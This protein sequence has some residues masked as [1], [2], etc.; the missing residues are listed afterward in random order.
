MAENSRQSTSSC[1]AGLL[2]TSNLGGSTRPFL[3]QNPRSGHLQYYTQ[4]Q[5]VWACESQYELRSPA[6]PTAEHEA[7]LWLLVDCCWAMRERGR[8]RRRRSRGAAEAAVLRAGLGCWGWGLGP[9][10]WRWRLT[11]QFDLPVPVPGAWGLGLG[12]GAWGA[13]PR[14]ARSALLGS[15]L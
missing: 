4:E 3:F 6:A 10:S 14:R 15:R 2:A 5:G 13:P 9:G 7:R 8:Q 11:P 12:L 1:T